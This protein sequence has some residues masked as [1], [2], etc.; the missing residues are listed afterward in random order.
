MEEY[1]RGVVPWEIGWLPEEKI[2]AL[3][4][5]AVAAR[6]YALSRVSLGTE[7]WDLVSTESDQVYRGLE[8]VDPVVDRAIRETAG[9]VLVYRGE[10]V[11]T[12]Y[13]STC[14]GRTAPLTDVWFHREGAPYL[15][16]VADG[17][18]G[19]TDPSRSYCRA[20]PHFR[21][22]E[23]WEGEAEI[24][25]ILRSLAAEQGVA[26]ERLGGLRDVRVEER[27]RSGRVRSTLFVTEGA[28]IRIP[29]D[30]VRWVLRRPDGGGIM[31]S[32]WF[33]LDVKR[34]RGVVGRIEAS[35]RGHGH[36][37]G[38][39]Q[40]GAMGMAADGKRYDEI[41]Q[42]YYPGARLRQADSGLLAASSSRE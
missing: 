17:P 29:G 14:G 12:Y 23:V 8:R 11:R 2:E 26:V 16:G 19:S 31:R 30:R 21:W 37:I 39:C 25:A 5:Q 13:S 1:L 42:H 4:A 28:E 33:T 22:T 24:S 20:S 38:L 6:T 27:G 15:R 9:L 18:G 32:T 35:G 7:M 3:K 41:L 40:W 10:L 34:D 36:G